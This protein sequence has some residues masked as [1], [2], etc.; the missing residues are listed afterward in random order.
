MKNKKIFLI[1]FFGI[2]L[3]SSL[4]FSFLF[5]SADLPSG[6]G[7]LVPVIVNN[8]LDIYVR[9]TNSTVPTELT[10]YN[11]DRY[12]FQSIPV[13]SNFYIGAEKEHSCD[14]IDNTD[15]KYCHPVVILWN[16]NASIGGFKLTSSF[17]LGGAYLNASAIK[18]SKN[19]NNLN[20]L[21]ATD[22]QIVN[23]TYTLPKEY[24][25]GTKYN[26]TIITN[27]SKVK[28]TN[29]APLSSFNYNL[30]K[31]SIIGFM[32]NF[33]MNKSDGGASYNFSNSLPFLNNLFLDPS[34]SACGTLYAGLGTYT[35]TAS[36][37]GISGTCFSVSDSNV[38]L[39]MNGYTISSVANPT[40]DGIYVPSGRTNFR[41]EN[42]TIKNFQNG[43]NFDGNAY[44]TI[45]NMTITNNTL[46]GI[47]VHNAAPNN[48]IENSNLSL[49]TYEG[50][51]FDSY[52]N[53]NLIFNNTISKNIL[54]SGMVINTN[55]VRNNVSYNKIVSNNL[56]GVWSLSNSN[57]IAYN[58]L[59]YNG[60]GAYL[61]SNS[62]NIINNNNILNNIHSGITVSTSSQ[63]NTIN[64]N[65]ANNN[66]ESGLYLNINAN[67]NNVTNNIF[68]SNGW[69]LITSDGC[70]NN[71]ITNLTANFNG[72]Q[73]LSFQ[74]NTNNNI[75][76]YL[77]VYNNSDD[78]I[79]LKENSNGNNFSNVDLKTS[80]DSSS[81]GIIW[82]DGSSNNIFEDSSFTTNR[83][84]LLIAIYNSAY[85]NS[86]NNIF[87]N[88]T[89][90]KSKE[91]ISNGQLIRE[92]YFNTNVS[93]QLGTLL[94]SANVTGYNKNNN[95]LFSSLTNSGAITQQN[96]IEYSNANV[97]GYS[98]QT[99]NN[100][101][102]SKF[103]FYTNST[104]YN[105]TITQNT[106]YNVILFDSNPPNVTLTNPQNQVY[107]YN[108][109]LPL[110]FTATDAETAVSSCFLQVTNSGVAINNISISNCQNTTFNL[111]GGGNY[112][113]TLFANDSNNNIG[114]ASVSFQV[115]LTAPAVVLNSPSNNSWL[116]SGLNVPFNFTATK[117]DGLNTCQFWNNFNGTWNNTYTWYQPT[118]NTMNS[119]L[120]NITN[121]DGSYNWNVNCSDN[122]GNAAYALN[123]FTVN[124]DTINPNVN[125]TQI[126][127]VTDYLTFTFNS[128]E[129]DTN[130]NTCTYSIYNSVGLIDGSNSNVSFSC[131]TLTSA[132]VTSFGNY[133]L[134]INATDLAGNIGSYTSQF[135]MVKTPPPASGGGSSSSITEVTTKKCLVDS[136]CLY[137]QICKNSECIN[138][139]CGDGVCQRTGN[140]FG[141]LENE[142]SCNQDC[143][144]GGNFSLDSFVASIFGN[145]FLK[146]PINRP[147]LF[148]S[149]Y[150]AATITQNTTSIKW[151]GQINVEEFFLN[152]FKNSPNKQCF[153]S[154]D[155]S[156]IFLVGLTLFIIITLLVKFEDKPSG[157]KYNVYK[158]VS[159]KYSRNKKRKGGS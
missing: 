159:V 131:N 72:V 64:N 47:Y 76:N 149:L 95:Y 150:S 118:N 55:S 74:K 3:I 135:T 103:G 15:T 98:Y 69:G 111:S 115:N 73:G 91:F 108:A 99:P 107:S 134:T 132:L 105:L 25:N 18:L 54:R 93:N 71:N 11:F 119:T 22:G 125:I 139:F 7:S 45:N 152:C 124:L 146:D 148:S 36:I 42:G 127:T 49:N 70:I 75:I 136:N 140:Y 51:Y 68:N 43:I 138:S 141:L 129:N 80:Y 88:A 28:F 96:V 20:I 4:Y 62:L 30:N 66:P 21:Y 87:L 81:D 157:R 145:C 143:P 112:V 53:D 34:I 104:L 106:L 153:W 151:N 126:N 65:V 100:F 9:D 17:N 128:T 5:V 2:L 58:N 123:N 31:S 10:N 38:I 94:N 16:K 40:G 110:N 23:E 116:K 8:S 37:T 32:F 6:K 109:S 92:W 82:I 156:S 121:G 158:Y 57:I 29:W 14:W 26:E 84:S 41:V 130:L 78:G 60:Y 117:R 67:Y 85:V 59:S 137:R 1:S 39:N 61:S 83:T 52:S 13:V 133:N 46:Y 79:G 63:Y 50:I 113:L 27:L 35:L 101:T 97:S 48:I 19:M 154:T 33:T 147:C 77:T 114:S 89:Y 90:N 142:Y 102:S 155:E 122:F 12:K 120:A 24:S 144:L 44:S 86:N 56:T